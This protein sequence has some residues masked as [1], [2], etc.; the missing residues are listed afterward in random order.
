MEPG[1]TLHDFVMKRH[2]AMLSERSSYDGNWQRISKV[3]LPRQSRFFLSNVGN[4]GTIYP[5]SVG[6]SGGSSNPY[7]NIVNNQATRSLRAAQAGMLAG[8]MSPTRKWFKLET[9][10]PDLMKFQPV[11]VWLF[12]VE[13]LLQAIFASG[14][15]YNMAPSLLRELLAFGTGCLAQVDDFDHVARFYTHTIGSYA[16][17]QNSRFDIDTMSRQFQMT[18]RQMK[19]SYGD[20]TSDTVT[21]MYDK[22]NYEAWIPVL[23]FVSPNEDFT[24]SRPQS[25]FKKFQS[26]H[27][28]M[29]GKNDS[30]LLKK[31]FDDF[32]LHCPRWDVTGEDI[33]ASDCPGITALGDT[34]SLQI[35]ERRK[36]QAIDKMVA[37]PLQGPPSMRNVP[38]QDLPGGLTIVDPIGSGEGLRPIYTVNPQI[39]EL[40][41]DVQHHEERIRAAFYEDLFRSIDSMEGVQPQNQ[42]FLSIKNSEKLLQLGPVLEQLHGELLN[43]IIDRT[44]NQCLRAGILPPAPQELQGIPLKVRYIS[45]MASAQ[46]EAAT[47]GIDKLTMYINGLSQ[48]PAFAQVSDKFDADRAFTDYATA[49]GVDPELIVSDAQVAQVRAQ[50]Q[51]MQMAQQSAEIAQKAGAGVQALANSPTGDGSNQNVL[52]MLS[53]AAGAR[54][55]A[56]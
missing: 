5:G 50:R 29:G 45:S 51:K 35:L 49:I 25:Q 1:E 7:S 23:Q 14:N 56:R 28:E 22:G 38:F 40:L 4:P 34:R 27:I 19:N 2:A 16:L 6:P 11:Q 31:G 8:V 33:Y 47:V 41:M 48:N 37:P 21:R 43:P 55:S 17:A 46:R 3:M 42:M 39:Q 18:V 26:V 9:P 20:R 53:Q 32:P 15:L 52:S 13:A 24:P 36:A 44:F 54:A 12:K 30:I 10:D